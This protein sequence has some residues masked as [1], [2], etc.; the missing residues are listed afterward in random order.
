LLSCVGAEQTVERVGERTGLFGLEQVKVG[1]LDL[2][3]IYFPAR[4]FRP[5]SAPKV[6]VGLG[7]NA[8]DITV[9]GKD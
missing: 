1:A 2:D 6:L 8:D 3:N 5:K 7:A 4:N 9:V